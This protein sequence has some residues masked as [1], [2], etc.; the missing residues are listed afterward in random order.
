MVGQHGVRL[1][2]GD[3]SLLIYRR[4]GILLR[5][6]ANGMAI[7]TD[8]KR[9]KSLWSLTKK[10]LARRCLDLEAMRGRPVYVPTS[11]S[12]QVAE[13]YWKRLRRLRWVRRQR[14]ASKAAARVK[15][16]RAERES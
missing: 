9:G 2:L 11:F 7:E 1:R 16:F 5:H 14:L 4:E 8:W 13:I 10:K 6:L 15:S 3:R 12:V